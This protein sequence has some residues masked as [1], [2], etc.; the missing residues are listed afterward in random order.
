MPVSCAVWSVLTIDAVA[1]SVDDLRDGSAGDSW[2]ISERMV[3][4]GSCVSQESI[5]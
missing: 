3:W 2:S 4:R 1:V 5:H